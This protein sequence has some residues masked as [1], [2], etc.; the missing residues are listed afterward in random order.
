MRSLILIVSAVV[1]P[2]LALASKTTH[3]TAQADEVVTKVNQA[4]QLLVEQGDS[5]LSE[6]SDPEGRFVWK[7]TYVFVVNCEADLVVANPMFPERVGG[8]IKQHTDYAGYAYGEELCRKAELPDGG[9][10]DYV[11]LIPGKES[12][13]RK[14]S[15]VRS[16]PDQPYEVGAGIYPR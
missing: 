11:W 2:G 7:D 16:V 14:R 1:L 12:P 13:Q 9:W 4:V 8:D 15:F 10:F 6:L 3:Q 5:A